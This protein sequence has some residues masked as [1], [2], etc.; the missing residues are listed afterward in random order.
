M[1][2][3]Q[4]Q[5]SFLES[6]VAGEYEVPEGAELSTCHSCGVT[7]T[8]AQTSGGASIPL[9][10]QHVRIIAGKRYAKTHFI[11]CPHSKQW[12]KRQQVW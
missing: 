7:I 9:D 6:P 11:T 8:W 3:L 12:R 10:L 2:E 5:T 4:E 1:N